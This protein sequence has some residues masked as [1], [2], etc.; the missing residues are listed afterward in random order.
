M[1]KITFT[2]TGP[3]PRLLG[4]LFAL[5]PLVLQISAG[6]LAASNT[7]HEGDEM[8]IRLTRP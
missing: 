2:P 1:N 3:R 8:R 4:C 5:A 7:S 6:T